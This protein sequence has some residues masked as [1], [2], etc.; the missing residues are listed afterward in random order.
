MYLQQLRAPLAL[1]G[2]LAKDREPLFL[3]FPITSGPK[4]LLL[5]ASESSVAVQRI[6]VFPLS[7]FP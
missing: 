1:C 6:R 7:H 5:M 4:P 2:L 3:Y